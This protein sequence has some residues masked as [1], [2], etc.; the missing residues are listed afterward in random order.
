LTGVTAYE[1]I[2]ERLRINRSDQS[3]T[4]L[5]IGGAGGV[6]SMA[7]QLAALSPQITVVAT[8]S[9]QESRKWCLEMGAHAVVNHREL[10]DDY[11]S[12]DLPAPTHILNCADTDAHW[13]SMAE[14]ITPMGHICSVVE[15][16]TNLDLKALM[17]KS[18][19]FSWEHM[20]TCQLYGIEPASSRKA[21]M[22]IAQLV[23]G[24]EI[25]PT[26]RSVLRGLSVD[27]VRE[28]HRQLESGQMIGKLV[29]E[30]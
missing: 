9:R 26:T 20:N 28:A 15:N 19:T 4:L 22:E 2:F 5:I 16:R 29:V 30:V 17:R 8:A 12:A 7:I 11:R 27:N 21:L 24:G 3:I 10:I 18:V 23:D 6:G 14:L 13:Q 25:H 1:A